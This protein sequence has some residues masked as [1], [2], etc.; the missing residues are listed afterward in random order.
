MM[1][2]TLWLQEAGPDASTGGRLQV[3]SSPSRQH[4]GARRTLK[5]SPYLRLTSP[6]PPSR[7][8]EPRLV[9]QVKGQRRS[10]VRGHL[11]LSVLVCVLT[12]S[13]LSGVKV[14]S[15]KTQTCLA[16]P[17]RPPPQCPDMVRPTHPTAAVA[18]AT[19]LGE[20][21]SSSWFLSHQPSSS[22]CSGPPRTSQRTP[23]PSAGVAG[24]NTAT[25]LQVS[26]A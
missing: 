14:K 17:P 22:R 6:C 13:H 3:G 26:L 7:R 9:E 23:P 5:K 21:D 16:P 10:Q 19:P 25:E 15:C 18:T 20:V 12:C 8:C 4:A 24:G 11:R 1:S 2:L